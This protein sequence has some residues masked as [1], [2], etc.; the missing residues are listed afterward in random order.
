MTWPPQGGPYPVPPGAAPL[1][2]P[3]PLPPGMPPGAGMPGGGVAGPGMPP[4]QQFPGG[5]PTP[6]APQF[7]PG[8]PFPAAGPAVPLPPPAAPLPPPQVAPAPGPFA[9]SPGVPA[10]AFGAGARLDGYRAERPPKKSHAGVIVL[11]SVLGAIVLVVGGLAALGAA[12]HKDK[13]VDAASTPP[14]T[15]SPISRETSPTR[16]TTES[17]TSAT[18]ASTTRETRETTSDSEP[19]SEAPPAPRGPQPVKE[20][21]RNPLFASADAGLQN[22]ACTLSRWSSDRAGAERF[23]Q[24][25]IRCLN[26]VWAPVLGDAGLPFEG[27]NLVVAQ[28]G[29]MQS[30]CTSS[31]DNF[32][33]YYCPTN[34]TIYMPMDKLQIEQ[35]GAHPGIYLAVLAHEY[36]HHV[37]NLSGVEDAMSEQRYDAGADSAAGLEL[38]RRLELQAQ[39]FSGM[40]LGAS[41][42]AGGSIDRNIYN[43]A[44]N[45][46]D[47]GDHG[48][49]P[50]DHG[51]DEHSIAWWRQGATKNRTQQCNTWAANSS[52]VA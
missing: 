19:A 9:A 33:A 29:Q 14:P 4:G 44:W 51:T 46:E 17:S 34:E 40:F 48:D 8:P 36:G 30:P 38:S 7:P 25:G 18:T 22:V 41:S 42:N 13:R 37:Q 11:V 24:S 28:S 52:D 45:S 6:P 2:P 21:A 3:R 43:E 31:G 32:A 35:Y 39:C 10:Q 49:G 26:T 1:P 5:P 23:F 12:V 15:Y 16:Y 50:R 47:R 20:T 27:P